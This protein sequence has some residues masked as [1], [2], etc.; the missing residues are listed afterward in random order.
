MT[1]QGNKPVSPSQS[2]E[3]AEKWGWRMQESPCPCFLHPGEIG[4][5]SIAGDAE[6]SSLSSTSKHHRSK[7][8]TCAQAAGIVLGWITGKLRWKRGPCFP[9]H[10]ET[11]LPGLT[12]AQDTAGTEQEQ[13]LM[14]DTR[15]GKGRQHVARGV[16]TSTSAC[17]RW[18]IKHV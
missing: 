4:E 5:L 16:P 1:A 15:H 13:Q 10:E 18:L 7:A 12:H 9:Q 3:L 11:G 14:Q 6:T 8:S 2:S 17:E